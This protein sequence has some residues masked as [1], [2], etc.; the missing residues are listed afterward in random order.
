MATKRSS[1]KSPVASTKARIGGIAGKLNSP[2]SV[3]KTDLA[4]PVQ[5]G[6]IEIPAPKAGPRKQKEIKVPETPGDL[7]INKEG[8]KPKKNKKAKKKLG[9]KENRKKK[10]KKDLRNAKN[11]QK[12]IKKALKKAKSGKTGKKKVKKIK[13]LYAKAS[14][15]VKKIKK[16]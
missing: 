13:L 6:N 9:K 3:P 16:G 12:K 4:A 1:K 5:S 2:A 14:K 10:I 7:K 8:K 15:K 11:K